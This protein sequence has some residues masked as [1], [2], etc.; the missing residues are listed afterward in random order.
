MATY[1]TSVPETVK[2]LVEVAS[3]LPGGQRLLNALAEHSDLKDG[4]VTASA[5]RTFRFLTDAKLN[6]SY[7][8]FFEDLESLS[9]TEDVYH[10]VDIATR[11]IQLITTE[12]PV[13]NDLELKVS[14]HTGY[15]LQVPVIENDDV[16]IDSLGIYPSYYKAL[17]GSLGHDEATI[18]PI[19]LYY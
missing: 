16:R 17:I 6:I 8:R 1:I 18:T 15:L 7:E 5:A 9:V 13:T 4:I 14:Q 12:A 3:T 11:I 10:L 2:A 19:K